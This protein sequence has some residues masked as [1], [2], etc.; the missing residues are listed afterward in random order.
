MNAVSR[1]PLRRL[2]VLAALVLSMLLLSAAPAFAH[3][4]GGPDASN[5]RSVV[6]DV[7]DGDDAAT[8]DAAPVDA[9]EVVWSVLANDS[10]LEVRNGTGEELMVLGYQDEP[11]LRIGPEGVFENRNSPATYLSN[12]RFATT[13][14]PETASP[15]AQPDWQQVSDEPVYAWHDHRIHWMAPTLPPQVKVDASQP[16]KVQDWSVPYRLANQDFAVRGTLTWEPPP[17]W[18]PWIV[19]PSVAAAVGIIP[20][21]ARRDP[22]ARRRFALQGGALVLGVVV[23][24]NV[25][26]G[27]DDI[28]SV[29]ATFAQN[30]VASLQTFVPIIIGAWAAWRGRTA[31]PGAAQALLIGTAA[32]TIGLGVTHTT[33][34][35]S[36]Q[37]ASRLPEWFSRLVVG[38]DFAII[39]S[40]AL[41]LLASGEMQRE[42]PAAQPVVAEGRT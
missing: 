13:P 23:I 7:V 20:A 27:I 4:G 9:G 40:T 32:V 41:A 36:S 16:V 22:D 10:L 31:S 12:D 15:D 5:Y 14:V 38:M 29:P 2:T 42:E 3:G 39:V 28:I 24:A 37:V 30:L 1:T 18:W 26:H 21:F 17:A 11:Y 8:P 6:R 35:A 19:I 25:V 34:L 33:V